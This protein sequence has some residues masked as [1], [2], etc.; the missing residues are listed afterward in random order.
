MRV[1]FALTFLLTLL[2]V[3]AAQTPLNQVQF[4]SSLRAR[5]TDDLSHEGVSTVRVTL[6]GT[7]L[8]EPIVATTDGQGNLQ[9]AGLTGGR[10]NLAIDKPGYFPQSF[11][12]IVVGGG[13]TGNT[14][15]ELGNLNITAQ[16]TASGTVRWDDGEPVANAIVHVMSFR[17]GAY[18]RA[19]FVSTVN[20]NERGEYKVEG[21]RARRYLVFAY[22]RP[23]VVRPGAAVRVALPVFYPGTER[24]ENA[25]MLDMRTNKD[26][27]GLS[28]VMKEERGVSIEGKITSDTLMPGSLAQVGLIIP[29][30]PTPFIV[31]T[32]TRVGEAFRLYPVPPGSY[33]LFARGFSAPTPTPA[34]TTPTPNPA[35]TV[36]AAG[37]VLPQGDPSVTALPVIV[38]RDTPIQDFTV[39]LPVSTVI[40]GKVEL[41]EAAQ[42][43]PS[44]IVPATG[45]NLFLEW[46]P[47]MESTYGFLTGTVNGQ[48]DFRL[49]GAV[50]GQAYVIGP[51]SNWGNAYVASIRQGPKD[52]L[53]GALPV[54]AGG[55][56]VH[57][58]LKRDGGRLEGKVTDGAR[59]PWRA[60][61]V[62][63]PRD[64]RIEFSFRSAFTMSDGSFQIANIPP[65]D[66]DIFAFDRNDEDI[67]YSGEFLRRYA[68]GGK[69][70]NV[71]PFV[72]QSVELAVTHTDK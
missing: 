65:G 63:A 47:K 45:A 3:S 27:S 60:F 8:R 20:T 5:I 43:M 28:L 69:A 66:Y 32:E 35:V 40:E 53:A 44:R 16:R 10:F 52:L 24:P 17:G 2:T 54:S 72:V 46:F 67:Y 58:L 71:T 15:L 64:R 31:G 29:G 33:L 61:V 26:M 59:V 39:N 48:G 25:Q 57:V 51:G 37:T 7:N 11:N 70:I 42:G 4:S 14:P 1:R 50:K 22:Q 12:D 21:L 9:I 6:T 49:T 34:G 36:S 56:P 19:A 41:D 30:V 68:V 62:V 18:S 13:E 23:Q 38:N 55:D